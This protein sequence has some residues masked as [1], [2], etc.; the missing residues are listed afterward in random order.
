MVSVIIPSFNRE[1]SI[2]NSIESVLDQ[3]WTDIEVIVVDDG[4]TDRTKEIVKSIND[5]RLKYC[6]QDNAGACVARNHGIDLAK[7]EYIAFHDSDDIWRKNKLEKQMN[8]LLND[9]SDIVFCQLTAH[10][11]N[12]DIILKPEKCTEGRVNPIVNLF[13][14]GTQ[15]IVAKRDVFR[16]FKFDKDLVRFQEFELLFRATQKFRLYCVKEPLVDY[17]VGRDSI[18]SSPEKMYSACSVLISK[19]PDLISNYPIMAEKMAHYLLTEADVERRSKK[20][21]WKKYVD[22]SEKCS[23]NIKL[24]VKKITIYLGCYYAIARHKA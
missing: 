2:K 6:Y 4:S 16:E 20:Q 13:G 14:I 1:V 22:L 21:D 23:K 24:T 7:G 10:L 15:T 5:D 19:H 11:N 17:Y 3:T 9:E 12:G 18:S 8:V